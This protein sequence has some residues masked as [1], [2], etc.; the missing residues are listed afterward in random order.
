MPLLCLSTFKIALLL[1]DMFYGTETLLEIRNG[2]I[3][4]FPFS[5]QLDGSVKLLFSQMLF[6]SKRV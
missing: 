2:L 6:Q 4:L 5:L 3:K 1:Y